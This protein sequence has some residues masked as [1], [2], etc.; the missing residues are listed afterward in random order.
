MDIT[1][2]AERAFQALELTGPEGEMPAPDDLGP[3]YEALEA[4]SSTANTLPDLLEPE[5][6]TR[7]DALRLLSELRDLVDHLREHLDE[8]AKVLW[9]RTVPGATTD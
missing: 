3:L 2:I 4:I 5:L 8:G 9:A 1:I 7:E 6:E